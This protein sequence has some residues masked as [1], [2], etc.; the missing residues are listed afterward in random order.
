MRVLLL[1]NG[2]GE[3][4]SG[5]LL[6]AQLITQG[7]SVV[8]MPL[9]GHGEP[10][11]QRNVP[12]VG[13]THAISTGGLGYTSMRGQLLEVWEGQLVHLARQV[14][15]L[16]R[17]RRQ[18]DL[19]VAVG[20]V[21]PIVG[22]WL[23]GRPAAV[24]LVAYSS[25]YEGQL[26]LPWP[27]GWL[28]RRGRVRA[29]WSRDALTAM[30]L[31]QQLGR[32]VR[33]VGNPFFD[34]APPGQPARPKGPSQTLALLPGSRLPEAL[35]NL[36]LMLQMVGHLDARLASA[37]GLQIKAAL[38]GALNAENLAPMAH[39][40]GWQLN[41]AGSAMGRGPW[42]IALVWG[43]F[44]E[45]LASSDLV[46]SMAGTATEQAV[47]LALPVLQ[48]A[49]DGP[50]F[51]AGFAEAQRR[52]LGDGLFWAPGPTGSHATLAQT[53]RLAGDLLAR[54]RDPERS[55]PLR[56]RLEELAQ[57]RIGPPGGSQRMAAAII[58]ATTRAAATRAAPTHTAT[59][60][61]AQ[62]STASMASQ[63]PPSPDG[64]HG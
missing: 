17:R 49:G 45:I 55:K 50:Q 25:H 22:A 63:H 56:Q 35:R 31:S 15:E 24:Y 44:G 20:D 46:L 64:N 1:S 11:R 58:A 28:L 36:A 7:V 39:S 9:V 38:V 18:F 10:Y 32:E 37:E 52:L 60:R 27:C 34:M 54:L 26:R 41:A 23:T 48:L 4:L 14:I 61:A 21:V 5:A 40:L 47:G 33:F 12:L 13:K 19:V 43:G 3:D 62:R 16:W 2:H 30:D 51:T 6:A 8:A 29:V 57:E 59:T 42:R 53:A